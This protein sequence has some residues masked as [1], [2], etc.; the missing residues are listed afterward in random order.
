MDSCSSAKS[1]RSRYCFLLWSTGCILIISLLFEWVCMAKII[2]MGIEPN[3]T[4]G[5][6]VDF[7]HGID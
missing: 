3:K 6:I 4:P 2:L 7:Q 1:S 5:N